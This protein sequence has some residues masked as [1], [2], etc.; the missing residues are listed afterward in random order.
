MALHT[1]IPTRAEVERLLETRDPCCVS[2]YLPTSTITQEAQAGRI[3][4]KTLAAEAVAQ[5]EAAG[6]D[7]RAVA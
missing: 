1:D 6:A 3:E 2:I 5:L 7:R 4:L